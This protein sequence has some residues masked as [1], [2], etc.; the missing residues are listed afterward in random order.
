[1]N[2]PTY[3]H[4]TFLLGS[5]GIER[6]GDIPEGVAAARRD[7]GAVHEVRSHFHV[8]LNAGDLGDGLRSTVPE[9][10]RLLDALVADPA[11]CD[12]FEIETYTWAVLPSALRAATVESQVGAEYDWALAEFAR[13]GWNPA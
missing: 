5:D 4:Q 8:P 2:E 7:L 12:Q 13:R 9:L 3:F 10:R 1:M 11:A 6:H